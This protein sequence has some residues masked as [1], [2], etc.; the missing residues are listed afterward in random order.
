MIAMW[1]GQ[2]DIF[3]PIIQEERHRLVQLR[4]EAS[5][6]SQQK[7]AVLA[8]YVPKFLMFLNPRPKA[9]DLKN[10][11]FWYICSFMCQ[12]CFGTLCI[13]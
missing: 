11:K 2:Y 9:E 4:R 1:S 8:I 3:G 6:Y 13:R 5:D 10:S 12:K 7:R